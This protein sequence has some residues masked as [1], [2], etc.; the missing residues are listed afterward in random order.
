M[1]KQSASLLADF[2]NER[3]SATHSPAGGTTLSVASPVP[4]S[5]THKLNLEVI[6]LSLTNKATTAQTVGA[7]VREASVAG[8]TLWARS[9]LIAI[10]GNVNVDLSALGIP[11]QRG[12]RVYLTQDT[13]HASVVAQ[14]N[15]A[16]WTDTGSSY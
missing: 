1:S 9:W 8:T 3:W 16:G 4:V 7:T 2:F 12:K 14:G 6:S 10:A 11:I 5:N 15:L 13:V